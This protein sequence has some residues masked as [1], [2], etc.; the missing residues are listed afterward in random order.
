MQSHCFVM[1]FVLQSQCVEISNPS[2]FQ[3][4]KVW[5]Q[6]AELNLVF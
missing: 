6:H 1:G 5:F 2:A 3:S 4:V